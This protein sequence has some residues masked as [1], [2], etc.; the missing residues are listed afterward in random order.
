MIDWLDL[1]DPYMIEVAVK[2]IERLID[3]EN[4]IPFFQGYHASNKFYS[5]MYYWL[6]NEGIDLKQRGYAGSFI[7]KFKDDRIVDDLEILY[8]YRKDW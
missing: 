7:E 8:E 4:I 6:Y 2:M 1:T 5:F 3:E